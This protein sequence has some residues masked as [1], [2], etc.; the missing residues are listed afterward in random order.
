MFSILHAVSRARLFFCLLIINFW[1]LIH[2]EALC[3]LHLAS[4]PKGKLTFT[5]IVPF[6]HKCILTIVYRR[7]WLY[8]SC[9]PANDS[10]GCQLL[11]NSGYLKAH[12]NTVQYLCYT[13]VS[14]DRQLG[15]R[16]VVSSEAP[17]I[18]CRLVFLTFFPYCL[19]NPKNDCA[20]SFTLWEHLWSILDFHCCGKKIRMV[21]TIQ[22]RGPQR[23]SCW[24][25]F[26]K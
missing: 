21:C 22:R 15:L 16:V 4:S 8:D 24:L 5:S 17:S 12:T 9:P 11:R 7:L 26:R 20:W 18:L 6:C 2:Q 10:W 23:Q 3:I 1:W 13:W 14:S 25:P 19:H